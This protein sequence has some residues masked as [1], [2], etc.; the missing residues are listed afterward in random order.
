MD[1]SYIRRW[2]ICNRVRV[3]FCSNN[4]HILVTVLSVVL[5]FQKQSV[6]VLSTKIDYYYC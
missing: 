5:F 1:R 4:N 3:T 2:R 6:I